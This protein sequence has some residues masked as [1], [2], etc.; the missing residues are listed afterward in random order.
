[1]VF[2]LCMILFHFHNKSLLL[3]LLLGFIL[4]VLNCCVIVIG[5]LVSCQFI[6]FIMIFAALY[7]VNACIITL[8][9]TLLQTLVFSLSNFVLNRH[10]SYFLCSP[11]CSSLSLIFLPPGGLSSST[12]S[13]PVVI[14]YSKDQ[15]PT[16]LP[17]QPFTFQHQFGKPQAKPL[18]PLLDGYISHMQTRGAVAPEAGEDDPEEDRRPPNGISNTPTTVRP[19]PLGSYSPVRLQ[20]APTSSGTCSTCTPS[21]GGPK[22]PRSLSCPIS[23]GLLPQHTPPGMAICTETPKHAPLPPTPPPPPLMKQSPLM[24]AL[25]TRNH[26]FHRDNLPTLPSSGL[27]PL[28]SQEE[29]V[30]VL[31]ACVT[32]RQPNGRFGAKMSSLDTTV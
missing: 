24:P 5:F 29:P 32:Q 2:V 16:S 11:P 25:P 15:R 4:A 30:K 1:M 31:P 9:D 22:P 26:C 3:L 6:S 19:S 28:A 27:G 20:G 23:A 18:L 17:I 7:V 21:P 8:N 10:L 14:R 12:D 13:S